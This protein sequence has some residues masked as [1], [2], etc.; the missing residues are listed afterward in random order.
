MTEP[1][2]P[3]VTVGPPPSPSADGSTQLPARPPARQLGRLHEVAVP[4]TPVAML[5]PVIGTERYA[6]LLTAAAQFRDRLG[7]QTIWNVSST[8]VGG[9]VAEMLPVLVGYMAGLDIAVRW[10]G[11]S[12]DPDFFAI[13][14]RL[15]NQIHGHRRRRAAEQR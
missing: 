8:A 15:H 7:R 10:A 4:G 12:G 2:A 14:K 1:P 3:H 11:I 9:G 6:Q 5:E 13:T